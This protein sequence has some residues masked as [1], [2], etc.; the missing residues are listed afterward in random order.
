MTKL[1]LEVMSRSGTK[2]CFIMFL[3]R[4]TEVFGD[5]LTLSAS[6]LCPYDHVVKCIAWNGR[7]LLWGKF[8]QFWDGVGSA[9]HALKE[10]HFQILK[11]YSVRGGLVQMVTW[12]ILSENGRLCVKKK[13]NCEKLWKIRS[14]NGN[15]R[16]P[17]VSVWAIYCSHHSAFPKVIWWK[18]NKI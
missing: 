17:E 10:L 12:K 18:F 8:G 3:A 6:T 7:S 2:A 11:K 4:D 1:K 5:T 14:E 15:L 16:V 13:K 9:G